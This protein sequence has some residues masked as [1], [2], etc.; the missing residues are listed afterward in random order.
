MFIPGTYKYSACQYEL[1]HESGDLQSAI[2]TG[3]AVSLP[4]VEEHDYG[5]SLSALTQPGIRATAGG[6]DTCPV[7]QIALLRLPL[8]C[9][10]S[11]WLPLYTV[12]SAF[13][14]KCFLPSW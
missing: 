14:A 12:P 11:Y 1:K 2:R 10:I 8:L 5:C 9:S 4:A 7:V 13:C 3:G 6:E